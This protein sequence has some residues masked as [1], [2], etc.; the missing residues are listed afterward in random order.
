MR[1]AAGTSSCGCV[2]DLVHLVA[3]GDRAGLDDVGAQAG[4]VDHALRTPGRVML[5][6]WLQG[7]HH[8]T[9]T[10]STLPTRKRLF[11]RSFSRTPVVSTWR[12]I[13]AWLSGMPV[14]SVKA[15]APRPRP[16]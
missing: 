4:A 15:R 13:S 9:P 1:R 14:S 8:S 2:C 5:W 10:A 16:A 7:S 12:R 6:M 11:S 3:H